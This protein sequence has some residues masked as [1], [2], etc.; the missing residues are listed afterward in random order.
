MTAI[1]RE[2]SREEVAAQVCD[3]LE[4]AGIPVV[5][6]GGAVVSIY[7]QSEYE[8]FDLD[9]V[10]IGLARR[11][12]A[13]MRDLGFRKAGRYWTHPETD[14]WVE[15]PLGP[16]QVGDSIVTEFAERVTPVGVLRLLPPT[17]CVM[18][19]LAGYFHWDDPQCLEQAL[20]VA[21]RQAIELE[22]VEAWSKREGAL[23]KFEI[24]RDRLRG[25]PGTRR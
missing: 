1:A 8:S 4:Q 21:R 19:R 11:V 5:L 13:V 16:V 18:D 3:A 14:F 7:S 23:H 24:F 6:S 17:E 2:H 10:R 25:A 12:D 22:R 15:F 9:F 20:A